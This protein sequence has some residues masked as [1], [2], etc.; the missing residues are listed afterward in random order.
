MLLSTLLGVL[1]YRGLSKGKVRQQ[2]Q[3]LCLTVEETCTMK[4][5]FC[6]P[7]AQ[8]TINTMASDCSMT[9][10]APSSH[11][12]S[13]ISN[14]HQRHLSHLLVHQKRRQVNLNSY[15]Q[16]RLNNTTSTNREEQGKTLAKMCQEH[17]ISYERC[18]HEAS[19]RK[20][21]AAAEREKNKVRK[22]ATWCCFSAPSRKIVCQVEYQAYREPGFCDC[23]KEVQRRE[24]ARQIRAFREEAKRKA[25]ADRIVRSRYQQERLANNDAREQAR[26]AAVG[27][28]W[29]SRAAQH[30]HGD[31]Y[32]EN[33]LYGQVLDLLS[34]P[35]YQRYMPPPSS[36]AG[37][38]PGGDG[39]FGG[40]NPHRLAQPPAPARVPV[41]PPG[42]LSSRRYKER[43]GRK[44]RGPAPAPAPAQVAR[45]IARVPALATHRR[46][47]AGA[48]EPPRHA[49]RNDEAS[50]DEYGEPVPDD[51]FLD[52][53]ERY[54]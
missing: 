7:E 53:V 21:C 47:M 40:S 24:R 26:R 38:N 46:Q 8:K 28:A 31:S 36:A 42:R 18:R 43:S 1:S 17:V 9:F 33:P 52:F 23:C 37:N 51:D 14:H 50:M 27:Y 15:Q 20:S 4:L 49:A 34:G 39:G 30:D 10:R 32:I 35:E 54:V 29:R 45:P 12:K 13:Y 5:C 3:Q 48:G 2:R 22:R 6:H 41:P 16:T 25:E 19:E 44:P 11:I